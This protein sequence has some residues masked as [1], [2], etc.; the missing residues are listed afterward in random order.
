MAEVV[1]ATARRADK[2]EL[3]VLAGVLARAFMDDPVARW[4]CRRDGLRPALLERVFNIR[5]RQLF[6]HREIWT[7]DRLASTAV[8]APPD[9]WKTTVS[10]DIALGWALARHPRLVGRAPMVMGGFLGVEATHPGAPPHWY[11]AIL[12]TDPPAQG[13][14]LA[15]E[16]MRP[17]L[18][19]CDRD[20]VGAYLESSSERNLD[21]Y[22]RHGFRVVQELR[23]PRGPAVWLMWRDP[24]LR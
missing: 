11:L 19:E 17:I 6:S 20:S 15:S 3:P 9:R 13:E 14:G 8:W 12:G 10:D 5:L 4:S 7:S 2:S 23:L 21:F 18:E 16:M 22:V 1:T 24:R